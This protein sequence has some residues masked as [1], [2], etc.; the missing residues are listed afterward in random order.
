MKSRARARREEFEECPYRGAFGSEATS[1]GRLF[2]NI[3]G[4]SLDR[5]IPLSIEEMNASNT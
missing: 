5:A 4:K 3:Y 1:Q 2:A